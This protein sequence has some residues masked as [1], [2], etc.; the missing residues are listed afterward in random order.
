MSSTHLHPLFPN[1]E[2]QQTSWGQLHGCAQDLLIANT[3]K[4]YKGLVVLV[5]PDSHSAYT[6]EANIR[7]FLGE[8]ESQ[9]NSL[10]HIFPDW[11]TL[12]YDVFS[13]HEDLIS[14]RLKTLYQL[15][16]LQQGVLIVPV[17]TL[18]LRLPPV[19]YIRSNTLMIKVGDEIEIDLLR[20]QLDEAGYRHTSQVMEHGEYS[21]R[22]SLVDLFP[23]GVR[24]PFRIDLFDKEIETIRSFNPEDQRTIEKI[25]QIELLPA[26]EFPLNPEGIARFR[27][28]YST[29]IAGDLSL[30]QIYDNVSNGTPPAGIEYY[31][32]LFF[33]NTATLFEY[34]PEKT[35]LINTDGTQ[36]SAETF[37]ATVADRYEQRRHDIERPILAPD[38]LYLSPDQLQ[39]N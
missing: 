32:P 35:L 1:K 39:D 17:S 9:E 5:T 10:V 31:L 22:G 28:N 4:E 3:A 25:D 18:M 36:A 12:P 26:H 16:T 23:M 13:P 24:K 21:T 20:I 37:S 34:L 29:R 6:A 27:E 14:D 15:S 11:E 38:A 19:E 30:S 7:F 33:D 2:S 8:S